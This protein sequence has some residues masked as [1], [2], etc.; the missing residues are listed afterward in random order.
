MGRRC[1]IEEKRRSGKSSMFSY[2][3]K[4]SVSMQTKRGPL[5]YL[6]VKIDQA[7]KDHCISKQV[8]V[9]MSILIPPKV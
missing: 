3:V 2:E 6:T 1:F 8:Q 9:K 5:M 4:R 7:G